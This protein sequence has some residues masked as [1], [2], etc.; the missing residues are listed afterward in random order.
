[1]NFKDWFVPRYL[2]SNPDVRMRFVQNSTDA[3]L[4][5]QMSEKDAAANVRKAAAER[6][7]SLKGQKRK[8]A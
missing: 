1:M 6:A 8:F 3:R 4:L 2:N 5:M 7:E